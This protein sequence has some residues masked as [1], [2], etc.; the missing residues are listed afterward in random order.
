MQK[1]IRVID[2]NTDYLD[3]FLSNN[4]KIKQISACM[5][6]SRLNSSICYVVIENIY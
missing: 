5:C 1:L 4:W 3:T 2:N 6:D